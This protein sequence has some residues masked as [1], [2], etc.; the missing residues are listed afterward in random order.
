MRSGRNKTIEAVLKPA[1]Q[2][3]KSM[4]EQM[5]NWSAGRV[6]HLIDLALDEDIGSGDIS[7]AY[8]KGIVRQG[9]GRITAKQDLVI[10]GLD[11]A[12]RVFEKLDTEM[13]F[14]ASC[15]DGD[16]IEKGKMIAEVISSL[17]VLL[18][19]E[20]TA[21]NFLQRMSGIA[22]HVR[23][24]VK[25]LAGTRV[26]LVDT[27][28]TIPGWRMLEKY[29]VRVGGAYNHRMGLYDGVLLKDN[30]IAAAGGIANAVVA[31]R[32]SVSHLCRIE[33][34]VTGLE[35]TAQA[36]AAGADIIMLDNMAISQVREAVA[37]IGN[38]AVVEVSGGVGKDSLRELADAGV[39]IISAGGLTHSAVAVDISM[40]IAPAATRKASASIPASGG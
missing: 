1:K 5:L 33:V 38:R 37:M 20:R 11:V 22:T 28:K 10:A 2:K 12:R 40:K 9:R 25:I 7:T 18:M 17:K 3:R 4:T 30:H 34:E 21:L 6:D 35:E 13:S 19:G 29:A 39:D 24:H 23:S 8:I 31:A 14:H 32:E 16:T 36:M 15:A 27:R 26:R